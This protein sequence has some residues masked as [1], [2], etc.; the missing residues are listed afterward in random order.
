MT[1]HVL[2]SRRWQPYFDQVSRELGATEVEIEVIGIGI[3]DQVHSEWVPLNGLSYDPKTDRMQVM[4]GPVDHQIYHPRQVAVD[5]DLEGLHSISVI[6]T[7]GY[8]EII[9]LRK[10]MM[11][12]MSD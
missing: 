9:K 12:P 1:I 8:R 10:P 2:E 11:L 6:N 4:A 3:G 5:D 7:E